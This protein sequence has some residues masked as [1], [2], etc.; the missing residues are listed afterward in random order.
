MLIGELELHVIRLNYSV[1]LV[2]LL[3]LVG[4]GGSIHVD[5]EWRSHHRCVGY[6]SWHANTITHLILHL[7]LIQ[8]WVRPQLVAT[9][10]VLRTSRRIMKLVSLVDLALNMGLSIA[11]V[12]C[13]ALAIA[14]DDAHAAA[15]DGE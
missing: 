11:L 14:N 8:I 4:S 9:L 7:R 2:L 3:D 13:L 15:Y 1:D 5:S 12:F 6:I 10:V